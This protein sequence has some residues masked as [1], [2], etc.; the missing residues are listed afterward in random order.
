VRSLR[1]LSANALLLSVVALS[2][3][4]VGAEP[5][6]V[7]IATV[8]GLGYLPLIVVHEQ[9]L[10]EKRVP[11]VKVEWRRLGSAVAMR[12][13]MIARQIDFASGGT[14]PFLLAV[15]RGLDWR[16][17]GAMLETPLDLV[18]NRADIRSVK[19]FKPSDRIAVPAL[20]G[21]QHLIVQMAAEKELGN[22]RALDANVVAMAPP[23]GFAALL[24]RR[25]ITAQMSSPPFQNQA[26]AR[27]GIHKILD[28][29]GV[30]GGP[31]TF[32]IV[33]APAA[34]ARDHR[35]LFD[36]VVASL[37]EATEY[38]NAHP[39]EAAEL[40]VRAEKSSLSVPQV[41]EIIEAPG[42]RYTMTPN[43]LVKVA[44]FMRKVGMLKRVPPSWKDY[45]FGH[46]RDSK[47]S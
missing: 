47:G 2:T 41:V 28:S 24:A 22:P 37:E 35:G 40:Y 21:I 30:G 7:R 15:D 39:R 8:P 1:V 42:T 10:I 27:P 14:A 23:D 20:G 25:D 26:L 31:S 45:T 32:T 5:N 13:A 3:A 12:E 11:G 16:I 46:L 29:Y 18:V 17:V 33:W 34:W 36:A 19:D 4:T 38:I 9:Q 6:T 44:T 43:G